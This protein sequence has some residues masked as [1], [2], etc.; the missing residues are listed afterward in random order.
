MHINIYFFVN[1]EIK[2]GIN[3]YLHKNLHN[4]PN[5]HVMQ[6]PINL[7]KFKYINLILCYTM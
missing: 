4:L 6:I 2:L 1:K 5:N 3:F 7:H